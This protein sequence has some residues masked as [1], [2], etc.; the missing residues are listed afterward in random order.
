MTEKL[1]SHLES[2]SAI[3]GRSTVDLGLNEGHNEDVTSVTEVSPTREF[4]EDGSSSSVITWDQEEEER[5]SYL[6]DLINF[7]SAYNKPEEQS[8]EC[9]LLPN[10]KPNKQRRMSAPNVAKIFEETLYPDFLLDK[11][12]PA[13]SKFGKRIRPNPEMDLVLCRKV[14]GA[15]TLSSTKSVKLTQVQYNIYLSN[16][17]DILKE[18]LETW[19]EQFNDTVVSLIMEYFQNAKCVSFSPNA[20][21][22][23]IVD[24]LGSEHRMP[25]P[26][27]HLL[28]RPTSLDI[29]NRKPE[30]SPAEKEEAKE[31]VACI[32]FLAEFPDAYQ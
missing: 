2:E 32:D 16:V 18:V 24:P 9:N 10:S 5:V 6:A 12:Y 31:T 7:T 26:A 20:S 1:Y 11:Q 25:L 29:W 28:Q 22:Y 13:M 27:F 3:P 19:F 8:S 15:S 21:K 30:F 14:S 4:S 17:K 23:Y